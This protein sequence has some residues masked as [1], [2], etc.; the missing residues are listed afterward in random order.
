VLD[1]C[2][3][4]YI[5]VVGGEAWIVR[6]LDECTPGQPTEFS[7]NLDVKRGRQG[8]VMARTTDYVVYGGF[9]LKD[10]Q[11]VVFSWSNRGR[12]QGESW[13]EFVKAM[14]R[15]TLQ[16]IERGDLESNVAAEYSRHLYYNLVFESE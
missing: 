8:S 13:Q 9:P 6:R 14:T 16:V 2:V 10:G 1:Y 7:H 11:L 12:A 4:A 5:A 15:E 3:K